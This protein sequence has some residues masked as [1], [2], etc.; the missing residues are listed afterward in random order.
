M[1]A[2]SAPEA[3]NAFR[4]MIGIARADPVLIEKH[5]RGGGVVEEYRRLA[6]NPT[7]KRRTTHN[8]TKI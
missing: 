8:E 7:S 1:K 2:M 3:N 4:S 5:G 6:G